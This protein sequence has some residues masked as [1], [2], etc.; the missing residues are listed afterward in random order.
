MLAISMLISLA[1][2][3]LSTASIGII[4]PIMQL[5]F[6]KGD[7]AAPATDG[8][9]PAP[10]AVDGLKEWFLATIN[11]LIADAD[12]LVTLRNLC[13]L[14][15]GLFLAKNILKYVGALLSTRIEEGMMKDVRDDIFRRTVGQSL[16]F[17]NARRGGELMSIVTNDVAG[18]SGLV[19]PILGTIIREP[20][21]I[22]LTLVLL[23]EFSPLL[24][25]IA[26]STSILSI[27]IIRLLTRSIKRYS[28]RL[29]GQLG[30]ITSR[31]QETF[32][33]I[34][35]IKGYAAE[36]Y[37]VERFQRDTAGYVRT[38]MKHSATTNMM[39]PIS[40]VFAITALAVVLF[41]GG[42]QVLEGRMRADELFSFLFLLFAIMQPITTVLTAPG[43]IQRGLASGERVLTI[44]ESTPEVVGGSRTATPLRNEL[45]LLN[46]G[47]A[48]R[49]GHAVLRD[50]TLTIKRGQTV[51][52][53]GPS[54]GG[55][56][57]L[58]DLVIRLYDPTTGG[59]SLDGVDIREF[60]L[61]SYRSLFGIVTQESILFNDS[62]RNNIAY[63]RSDLAHDRV[64]EA[65]RMANAHEFISRL[66]HGYDTMIG[67]RGV[68]LSGGQRQR[69]AIARALARDPQVLL[70]DEATSALDTESEML[71]QEAINRLLVDRTAIV[72]AHRLS[73]VRNAD[74]IVVLE[75]GRV[76]EYGTHEELLEGGRLYRRLYEVQFREE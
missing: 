47:F 22:I 54:G 63:T 65:A 34:R 25:L 15:A 5:I 43:N 73:T 59:I 67:D 26:F 75:E 61:E 57:T 17:F 66:P 50:V 55:K 60:D 56:S 13:F 3:A 33:N 28:A 39:S 51:A 70:F 53:V 38:A 19:G 30:D 6:P 10:E 71:V 68:L 44:L 37:E 40:E 21:Q 29:Q 12:P 35:I 45:Q 16:G 76:V 58:V 64:V 72:I 4:G 52:L 2:S 11:G 41:Y 74:L 7:A 36:R 14:I 46:V 9:V 31:L 32:Q 23:I 27:V 49:E 48:Y 18:M 8:A 24:T 1:I 69:L 42:L 62:V 20:V